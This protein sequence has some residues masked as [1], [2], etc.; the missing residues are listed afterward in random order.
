MDHV[1]RL[2]NM[3]RET[4]PNLIRQA[5]QGAAFATLFYGA[6]TWYSSKTSQWS[7]DQIQGATNRAARAVLP[8]FKTTSD[9]TLL[10]ETGWSPT[11]T[12]L[13]RFHDDLAIRVAATDP[14]DSQR[15]C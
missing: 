4:Q 7:I 13:E 10:R 11:T 6:E 2:N 1:K 8:V 3:I 14:N 12:W 5:I 9:A 15:E